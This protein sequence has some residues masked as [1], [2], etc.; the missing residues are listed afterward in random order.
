MRVIG[1]FSPALISIAIKHSRNSGLAWQMPTVLVEYGIYVLIN[2]WLTTTIITYGLNVSGV[3]VDALDSFA[4]F[5]KYT[6]IAIIIA[7]FISF[8]QEIAKKYIEVTFVVRKK[9][10]SLEDHKKDN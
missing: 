5:T 10:E 6:L 2:V 9:D 4:F 8:I 1:L 7:V 3:T